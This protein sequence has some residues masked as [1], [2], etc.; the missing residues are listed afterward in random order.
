MALATVPRA[1]MEIPITTA[2]L[3][4]P[5]ACDSQNVNATTN[6][7]YGGADFSFT[8]VSGGGILAHSAGGFQACTVTLTMTP[9]GFAGPVIAT[10]QVPSGWPLQ[11]ATETLGPDPSTFSINLGFQPPDMPVGDYELVWVGTLLGTCPVQHTAVQIC[12]VGDFS[13]SPDPTSQT[14]QA[15]RSISYWLRVDRQNGF[16]GGLRVEAYEYPSEMTITI[17]PATMDAQTSYTTMTVKTTRKLPVGTYHV[18]VRAINDPY[19]TG[20]ARYATVDVVVAK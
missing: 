12:K 9:T 5:T 3:P 11:P 18:K 16:L 6:G 2:A 7:E 1:V 14:V 8:A 4:Y 13:I 15:G 17:D 19:A 10:Q 20:G